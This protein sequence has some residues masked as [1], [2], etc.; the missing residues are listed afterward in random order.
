MPDISYWAALFDGEGYVGVIVREEDRLAVLR[1]SITNNHKGVLEM[2]V[3]EFGGQLYPP[4]HYGETQG[5]GSWTWVAHAERAINF[6]R[7][8]LPYLII[9]KPQAALA[10]TFPIGKKGRRAD[11]AWWLQ[12][13]AIRDALVLMKRDVWTSP[14]PADLVTRQALTARADVLQAVG[15]YRS[16]LSTTVVARRMGV[17]A[18]A[19]GYW[20]RCL[21][22]MR[23]RS[24]A[25]RLSG[26]TRSDAATAR[27]E[28]LEAREMYLAETPIP[29][30]A[31]RLG[32]PPATV[33]YWLRRQGVTRSLVEAQKLR[34]QR[35][36]GTN[37]QRGDRP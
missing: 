31:R 25:M 15:L 7:R 11:P 35:E 2:L 16:G 13:V 18:A 27:P 29:E 28:A 36:H 33:N 17:G 3:P 34:R 4:K 22:I 24:E 37:S 9:K 6:L 30:I 19:V 21:G 10:T 5:K 20:M 8:V 1:V 12:R 14:M 26:A 32:H 23:P